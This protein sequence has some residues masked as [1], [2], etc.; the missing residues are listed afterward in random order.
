MIKYLQFEFTRNKAS[1]ITLASV[2]GGVY[3][4]YFVFLNFIFRTVTTQIISATETVASVQPL[5][6]NNLHALF[7]ILL[8]ISPFLLYK[9]L[10]NP[11]QGVSLT[12]LPMG[13]IEKFAAVLLQCVIIIPFILIAIPTLLN[14]VVS[15]AGNAPLAETWTSLKE[16]F[17]G[18]IF[19]F[20]L[21]AVAIWGV[22]F[23]RQ[24]KLWKTVLTLL[25]VIAALSVIMSI[26]TYMYFSKQPTQPIEFNI[27]D[28]LPEKNIVMSIITVLLWAWGYFKMR[29]QQL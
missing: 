10:F 5:D 19:V 6:I 9:H 26:A 14:I 4:V 20:L 8:F 25:C 2:M 22:L 27:F 23:F 13:Q 21:Q 1:Y 29:R 17:N 24:R 12:M 28:L 15:L 16:F 11:V 3:L 18:F 7:A